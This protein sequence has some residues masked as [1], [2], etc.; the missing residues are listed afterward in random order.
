MTTEVLTLYTHEGKPVYTFQQLCFDVKGWSSDITLPTLYTVR[1]KYTQA[2]AGFN[3]QWLIPLQ[4][5]KTHLASWNCDGFPHPDGIKT[6]RRKAK[7]LPKHENNSSLRDTTAGKQTRTAPAEKGIHLHRCVTS[8]PQ[9]FILPQFSGAR[10][11]TTL[12]KALYLDLFQKSSPPK[13]QSP[14]TF[15]F[16]FWLFGGF[17]GFFFFKQEIVIQMH[18]VHSLHWKTKVLL[19]IADPQSWGSCVQTLLTPPGLNNFLFHP[20]RH[21]HKKNP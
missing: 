1:G 14:L 2:G 3:T 16:A 7:E 20:W 21:Q 11:K 8:F 13:E 6:C 4:S 15:F 18:K 9:C 19:Q 17:F 12:H 10:S 5:V